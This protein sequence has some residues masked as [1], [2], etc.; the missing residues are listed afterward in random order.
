MITLVKKYNT[1]I[2]TLPELIE[3]SDY[4][5]EYYIKKLEISKPTMYRKLREKT[6]TISEITQLTRLLFPKE[7]YLEE[8]KADLEKS[9]KDIKNGRVIEHNEAIK[10]IYKDYL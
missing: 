2:N 6:F 10:A 7:T 1:Y 4:K 3:T 8:I 9:R 5:L